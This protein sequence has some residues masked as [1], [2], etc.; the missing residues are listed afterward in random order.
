MRLY[1]CVYPHVMSTSNTYFSMHVLADHSAY[2]SAWGSSFARKPTSNGLKSILDK[3]R[4]TSLRSPLAMVLAKTT[5]QEGGVVVP[6]MLNAN[7]KTSNTNDVLI[8]K[9]RKDVKIDKWKF[10]PM[11]LNLAFDE[12]TSIYQCCNCLTVYQSNHLKTCC[13][14]AMMESAKV[15]PDSGMETAEVLKQENWQGQKNAVCYL[16]SMIITYIDQRITDRSI[17]NAHRRIWQRSI[18]L[19]VELWEIW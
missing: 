3:S 5:L 1:V 2:F 17:G 4:W 16:I 8:S 15:Q 10:S 11:A 19:Q 12:L 13:R 7:S 14:Q 18:Q 9:K 6:L